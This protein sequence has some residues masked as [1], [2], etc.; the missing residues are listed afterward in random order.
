MATPIG[1]LADISVRALSVLAG[2]DVIA[3]EDTR[4][5]AKLLQHYGLHKPLVSYHDHNEAA[6][7]GDLVTRIQSGARVALCSDAGCPVISDPGYRVVQ[8]ALQ[9]E[10]FLTSVPGANAAVTALQLSGLPPQPFLF[11]GFLPPKTHGR[12]KLFELYKDFAGTLIG[13]ESPH[14]LLVALQD[15]QTVLGERPA[16]VAREL[17]KLYEEVPR[18]TI[19]ELIMHYSAKPIKG[20]IV[21][22]IGA[23]R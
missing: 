12:Q 13:Y 16:A 8:A 2:C 15:A 10:V 3:C 4:H 9:A 11:V 6:R 21:L 5:T 19:G 18:G 22:L 23:A 17:T 7:S 14:R 20:E 1:N